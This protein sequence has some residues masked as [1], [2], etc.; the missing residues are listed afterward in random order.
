MPQVMAPKI[1]LLSLDVKIFSRFLAVGA[2]CSI[3]AQP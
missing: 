2:H 3:T 1:R